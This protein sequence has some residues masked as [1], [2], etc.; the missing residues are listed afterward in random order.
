[1]CTRAGCSTDSPLMQ[2]SCV[3]AFGVKKPTRVVGVKTDTVS[4]ME[5][6]LEQF[7]KYDTVSVLPVPDQ[8]GRFCFCQQCGA[9]GSGPI[10]PAVV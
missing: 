10:F 8:S 5:M 2:L 1:M 6:G 7:F 9:T 3:I 4:D